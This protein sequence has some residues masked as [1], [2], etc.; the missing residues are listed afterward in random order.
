MDR[1]RLF[2]SRIRSQTHRRTPGESRQAYR[3][4]PLSIYRLL[5]WVSKD[6]GEATLPR[7]MKRSEDVSCW[8]HVLVPYPNMGDCIEHWWMDSILREDVDVHWQH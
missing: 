1:S 3:E 8:L 7:S 2:W 4:G 6:M 5:L